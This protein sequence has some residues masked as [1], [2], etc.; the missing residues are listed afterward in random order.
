MTTAAL[1]L[2]NG[3][4]SRGVKAY[5]LTPGNNQLLLQSSNDVPHDWMIGINEDTLLGKRI[6]IIDDYEY[7][8][9]FWKK[10]YN[11]D[12]THHLEHTSDHCQAFIF[13]R[14]PSIEEELEEKLKIGFC[15]YKLKITEIPTKEDIKKEFKDIIYWNEN[16]GFPEKISHVIVDELKRKIAERVSFTIEI[17]HPVYGYEQVGSTYLDSGPDSHDAPKAITAG[18][19]TQKDGFYFYVPCQWDNSHPLH[20]EATALNNNYLNTLQ[21]EIRKAISKATREE[22]INQRVHE[23]T[24][25]R[26]STKFSFFMR[27]LVRLRLSQEEGEVHARTQHVNGENQYLIHYRDANRC[28]QTEWFLESMLVAVKH[29]GHGDTPVFSTLEDLM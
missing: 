23:S 9:S 1:S 12:I 6:V 8:N 22:I 11:C 15:E 29:F 16:W 4:R 21:E 26:D 10:R 7:V 20:C 25:E 3:Y 14:T 28:V 19:D 27:Q 24:K 17:T 13:I 18:V 5:L 2:L